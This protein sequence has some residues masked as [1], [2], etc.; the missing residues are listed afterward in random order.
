VTGT[1]DKDLLPNL[2]MLAEKVTGAWPVQI[3]DA[4][5]GLMQHNT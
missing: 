4:G 3:R 1:D 5:H 2:I